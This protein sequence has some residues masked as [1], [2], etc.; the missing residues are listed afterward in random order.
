MEIRRAEKKDIDRILFLLSQVLEVHA[1]IRPDIFVSGT[2]K[3]SEKD[4]EEMIK[5]DQKP[6]YVALDDGLV[7]G[8][9]FSQIKEP[10]FSSTMVKRK[11]FFIDDLCVD[12]TSRGKH[13]GEKLFEFAKSEAKRLGCNDI[14]LNVWTGNEG[15]ERF[16]EKMGMKTRERQMEN[17]L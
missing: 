10:A 8:Y 9:I 15:A 1:S 6:I 3:Y 11:T 12:E 17:M 16:Y 14:T 13:L 5:D 4:L 7:V 2:T